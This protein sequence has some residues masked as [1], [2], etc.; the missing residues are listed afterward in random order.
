MD[1]NRLLLDG[2]KTLTV[3][4]VT[5]VISFTD[6]HAV[7][8]TDLGQL[9]IGGHALHMDLLDLDKKEARLSGQIDSLWYP[10]TADRKK[11]GFFGKL[12]A[13]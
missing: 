10:E 11:P 4:G 8:E 3:T 7:I 2:R 6:D 1:E 13:K 5:D 9:Q 12:F